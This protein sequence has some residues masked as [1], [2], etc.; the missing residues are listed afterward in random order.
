MTPLVRIDQ[1]VNSAIGCETMALQDCFSGYHQ[2]W[3]CKEDEKKTCFITPFKTY[4]YLRMPEGLCNAGS[5]FC[6]MMKAALKDQ[7][8]GNVLSHVDDI[9]IASEKKA[10]Y[11]SDLVETFTNMCEA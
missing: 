5:T 9:V 1:I 6:R 2:I 11:I 7:V 3:L 8:G 4:F 10:T